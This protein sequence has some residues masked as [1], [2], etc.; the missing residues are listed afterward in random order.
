[1][2]KYWIPA[3]AGM[4]EIQALDETLNPLEIKRIYKKDERL[5]RFVGARNFLLTNTGKK[6]KNGKIFRSERSDED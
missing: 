4:T 2:R 3:S 5:S 1:M 6:F